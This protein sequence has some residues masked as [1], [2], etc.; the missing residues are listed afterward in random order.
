MVLDA[1]EDGFDG[2]GWHSLTVGKAGQGFNLAQR[3][4]LAF[5]FAYIEAAR[6]GKV[7][8]PDP[9]RTVC[10]TYA[11]RGKPLS[12]DSLSRWRR[13]YDLDTSVDDAFF[14]GDPKEVTIKAKE[15]LK[16]N[17]ALVREGP[18]RTKR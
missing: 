17:S 13:K 16:R 2:H 6:A 4:A 11:R 7:R 18:A 9:V 10:E 14:V 3:R 15:H 8:D 5:G 1:I 12:P